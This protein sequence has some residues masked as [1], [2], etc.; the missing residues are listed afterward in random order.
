MKR[1]LT[2]LVC[3]L[4]MAF[5]GL[6]VTASP[7]AADHEQSCYYTYVPNTVNVW[8]WKIITTALGS[9]TTWT[10]VST[11][12]VWGQVPVCTTIAH[13]PPT[14]QPPSPQCQ[15]RHSTRQGLFALGMDPLT[16]GAHIGNGIG[17]I[18]DGC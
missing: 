4:A 17:M 11:T 1:K 5:G 18:R 8:G 9:Y 6:A 14:T 15:T 3:C 16:A 2:A 10:V 7:A 13:P 12:T